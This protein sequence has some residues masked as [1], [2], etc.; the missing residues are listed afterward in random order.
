LH[1]ACK[2]AH[3][4]RRGDAKSVLY[5]ELQKFE[6]LFGSDLKDDDLKKVL[7]IAKKVFKVLDY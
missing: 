4:K 3:E 5:P 7:A 2:L 1:D 6:I